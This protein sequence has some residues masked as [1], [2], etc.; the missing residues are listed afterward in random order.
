VFFSLFSHVQ[1]TRRAIQCQLQD[2]K[3]SQS[4]SVKDITPSPSVD[5]SMLLAAQQLLELS[6]EKLGV[7]EMKEEGNGDD[8]AG[9]RVKELEKLNGVVRQYPLSKDGAKQ[10]PS[11]NGDKHPPSDN[12]AK[13]F[14]SDERGKYPPPDDGAKHPLSDN[15]AK[16]PPSD[17]RGKYPLPDDGAK[18]PLSDE[19]TSGLPVNGSTGSPGA[20]G[21]HSCETTDSKEGAEAD[22]KKGRLGSRK[23]EK[24]ED[25]DDKGLL[26]NG[27]A[28][29]KIKLN[30]NGVLIEL[31]RGSED[32]RCGPQDRPLKDDE[33]EPS[34]TNHNKPFENSISKPSDN[35]HSYTKENS[36]S[37]SEPGEGESGISSLVPTK[38]SDPVEVCNK[39]AV[40]ADPSVDQ[41][42]ADDDEAPSPRPSH[43]SSLTSGDED[44][45]TSSGEGE[46]KGG[47]KNGEWRDRE[48]AAEEP[49]EELEEEEEDEE[50]E[51]SLGEK[52]MDSETKS[53]FLEDLFGMYCRGTCL[54]QIRV[55]VK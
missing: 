3:P 27:E 22:G 12:G 42:P 25:S 4:R 39:V 31:D 28:V 16:H 6:G 41:P 23:R 5:V 55:F 34:K 2:E 37:L 20:N 17:G 9:L 47:R 40:A 36:N 52:P 15:G 33:H 44:M 24:I 53:K 11:D 19:G 49:K 7:A 46:M 32:E 38:S 18:Y 50:G 30:G 13:H 43:V 54:G 45:E 21:D 51:G 8:G 48:P 29:K 10:P 26:A 1:W 14:P 35:S